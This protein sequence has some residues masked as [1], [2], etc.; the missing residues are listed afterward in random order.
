MTVILATHPPFFKLLGPQLLFTS[1]PARHHVARPALEGC[2]G[3]HSIVNAY[4]GTRP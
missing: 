1:T 4:R 2:A 3:L